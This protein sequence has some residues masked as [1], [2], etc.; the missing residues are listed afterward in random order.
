MKSYKAWREERE[1][2][3]AQKFT[4]DVAEGFWALYNEA[5]TCH[6]RYRFSKIITSADQGELEIDPSVLGLFKMV[7]MTAPYQ[8]YATLN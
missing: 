5:L 8:I 3:K 2:A 1:V 4:E 7:M 6:G